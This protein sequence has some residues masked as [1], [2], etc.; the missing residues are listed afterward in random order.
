MFARDIM[1]KELI[2]VSPETTVD[3]AAKIMSEKNISGL[4]V[5]DEDNRIMGI[6]TEGDLLGKHKKI[7]PPGYIEFLGGII[8][9]ESQDEYFEQLQKYVATKVVQLMS[10]DVVTVTPDTPVE[11]LP[12]LMDQKEIKR[13]LVTEKGKLIGIVSRADVIRALS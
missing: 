7:D 8:F 4:P 10:T 12:T 2:T 11:E 9:T 1:T 3:Q 6:V 5:I 13:V